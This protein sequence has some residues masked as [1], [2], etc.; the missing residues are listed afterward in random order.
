[1]SSPK[2]HNLRTVRSRGLP[3]QQSPNA[4]YKSLSQSRKRTPLRAHREANEIYLIRENTSNALN[5]PT[6]VP[7]G[8]SDGPGGDPRTPE[9]QTD[10]EFFESVMPLS[11]SGISQDSQ[12]PKVPLCQGDP[13]SRSNYTSSSVVK[14]KKK[15][16]IRQQKNAQHIISSSV[17]YK[18]T[19]CSQVFIP[20]PIP[21]VSPDLHEIPKKHR[22]NADYVAAMH[23][24]QNLHE[25]QLALRNE[26]SANV[27]GTQSTVRCLEFS[28]PS[29]QERNSAILTPSSRKEQ[30]IAYHKKQSQS[31]EL[32]YSSSLHVESTQSTLAHTPE[33]N[34]EINFDA[35]VPANNADLLQDEPMGPSLPL[36]QG[37]H[38][39]ANYIILQ[40]TIKHRFGGTI[41]PEDLYFVAHTLA[42]HMQTFH[43]D[44]VPLDVLTKKVEEVEELLQVRPAREV[45]PNKAF[46]NSV[47]TDVTP[48]DGDFSLG[49]I[50]EIG[51]L[52][53]CPEG[54]QAEEISPDGELKPGTWTTLRERMWIEASWS[55][56][57]VEKNGRAITAVLT[58]LAA[59]KNFSAELK[60]KWIKQVHRRFKR[61]IKDWKEKNGSR[62]YMAIEAHAK[63]IKGRKKTG[64][65][66]LIDEP[67]HGPV[68]KWHVMFHVFCRRSAEQTTLQM[69]E[70]E[71]PL[72]YSPRSI[73][74][75]LLD[76]TGLGSILQRLAPR[77]WPNSK[78][79]GG[80]PSNQ[81]TIPNVVSIDDRPW[82]IDA[83]IYPGHWEGD[84]II[85]ADG[86][87][88]IL[89][90]AERYTRWLVA[91]L[92]NDKGSLMVMAKILDE[93]ER[94]IMFSVTFDRGGEFTFHD[95]LK[96]AGVETFF[97]NPG[98]PDEKGLV[99]NRNGCIRYTL[100]KGYDFRNLTQA[101]LNHIVANINDNIVVKQHCSPFH[102][103]REGLLGEP[104]KIHAE[105]LRKAALDPR[106]F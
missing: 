61:E 72:A 90:L 28:N 53:E 85:G 24:A 41:R 5:T 21:G 62:H 76:Q 104:A 82:Y 66:A 34:K 38:V 68:R 73:R 97:C 71:K 91:I 79:P 67:I 7:N 17:T 6:I 25:S 55:T 30:L 86:S 78:H 64:P 27:L 18:R 13:P 4:I 3:D 20:S 46:M 1:M 99:E 69:L 37:Y 44:K 70:A 59:T 23:R 58:R 47:T 65:V 106:N 48:T 14:N 63:H 26:Q 98:C 54:E 89:A 16:Q 40:N 81:S 60:E 100:E 35:D 10:Y 94:Y 57:N 8:N 102:C 75:F 15:H 88:V 43:P 84:L 33:N 22:N 45:D 31:L 103:L 42:L 93:V 29:D 9:A 19:P 80:K 2:R 50:L 87:G 105:A 92:L 11:A 77:G 49:D 74:R 96:K 12:D 39:N 101:G 56:L 36:P 52:D 83:K 95:I 32:S 51:S